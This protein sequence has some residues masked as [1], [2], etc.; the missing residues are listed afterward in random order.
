MG[1]WSGGVAPGFFQS[2]AR[3]RTATL[4]LAG[5]LS[6][7]APIT[8]QPAAASTIHPP[9]SGPAASTGT[10]V[11]PNDANRGN[12]GNPR[13]VAWDRHFD[14]NRS[15]FLADRSDARYAVYR[16]PD[17]TET[18]RMSVDDRL[19]PNGFG[20]WKPLDLALTYGPDG[21]LEP[22]SPIDRTSFAPTIQP[23]LARLATATGN[24]DLSIPGAVAGVGGT[25][26]PGPSGESVQYEGSLASHSTLEL[27]PL[28]HGFEAAIIGLAPMPD[29]ALIEQ[30]RVP[31]GDR[32]R[33]TSGAIVV[34]DARNSEVAILSG[35]RATAMVGGIPGAS[36]QLHLLAFR[37]G[38]AVVRVMVD[39][40]WLG[41]RA[42]GTE[43]RVT[44]TLVVP[45]DVRAATISEHGSAPGEDLQVGNGGSG[46]TRTLL[47][48]PVA[49]PTGSK[50]LGATLHLFE[51]G[52]ASCTPTPVQVR[53]LDGS[54][55]PTA[56]WSNAP[57]PSSSIAASA[58]AAA[59][60]TGCQSPAWL[61]LNLSSLVGAWVSGKE[62]NNGIAVQ[63]ADEQDRMAW[64]SFAG[65][66]TP[67][68]PLLDVT[69]QA[70]RGSARLPITAARVPGFTPAVNVSSEVPKTAPLS[71]AA[72]STAVDNL[73]EVVPARTANSKTF[74]KPDKTL[75][76]QIYEG[77]IHIKD[78]TG[79]WIDIDPTL[80]PNGIGRLA[81]K[82]ANPA[83]DVALDA[84][85]A[86]LARLTI[87]SQH[88]IA[89]GYSG[90]RP[91]QGQ[92]AANSIV[93]RDISAG[94]DLQVYSRPAGVDDTLVLKSA[95]ATDTYVFPLTLKGLKVAVES[96]TGDL[97]FTDAATGAEM[98]RTPSGFMEDANVNP[99]SGL[100]AR[101]SGVT[102]H[103]V[104]DGKGGQAIQVTL[105][106]AWLSDPARVYP[107]T[108][109]PPVVTT[110]NTAQDD[111]YVDSA[112]SGDFASQTEM[113]VGTWDSGH[114]LYH[115]YMHFDLSPLNG[116]HILGATFWIYNH[117]SWS[118]QA[119]GV[120]VYRVTQ[121]WGGHSM[122]SWPGASYGEEIAWAAFAHGYTPGGCGAAWQ[123]F[124]VTGAVT[125][126]TNGSWPQYGLM[127]RED[128]VSTGDNYAWKRF[129]TYD[130]GSATPHIDVS[131][132][133]RPSMATL[134]SPANG[135]SMNT[136]TPT[137]SA[138][139]SSPQGYPIN[140]HYYI[141]DSLAHAQ[142]VNAS[143][144][145]V[146]CYLVP[147]NGSSV[148]VPAPSPL[149][150]NTQY[151]WAVLVD[152][153]VDY[154]MQP[155]TIWSF[156]AG[157]PP[158]SINQQQVFT[159]P[160]PTASGTQQ[161]TVTNY[162]SSTW[163]A[164]IVA[165][166]QLF[167]AAGSKQLLA[168]GHQTVLPSS[169]AP[170]ASLSMT[171]TLDPV[172][173]GTYTVYWDLEQTPGNTWFYSPPLNIPMLWAKVPFTSVAPPTINST[174]PANNAAPPSLTPTLSVSAT[175]PQGQPLTYHF[176]LC[177]GSDAN[178]G[179]CSDSGTISPSAWTIPKNTLSWGTTYYWVVYVS[180]S[181]G[182][183]ASAIS[184][185]IP[186]LP[187]VQPAWSFGWDPFASYSAGVNTALGNYVTSNTDLKIA[188]VGPSLDV[189]RTFNSMDAHTGWFGKGWSS[190]YETWI[191][192][193][194]DSYAN[195]IIHYPDGRLEF[196]SNNQDGTFADA[197]GFP[198]HL[199]G[200]AS[201]GYTLTSPDHS[202]LT[203]AA[204]SGRLTS[205]QDSNGRLLTLSYNTSTPPQL[206]TV[207]DATSGRAVHLAWTGNQ[208]SSISSDVPSTGV[209]PLTVYYN[210]TAGQLTSV[211]DARS[212]SATD[213]TYCTTF[214][215]TGGALT[216]ISR[217]LGNVGLALTYDPSGRVA[218]LQDGMTPANVWNYAYAASTVS[219]ETKQTTVTDA[220]GNTAVSGYNSLN[221][222]M[223]H[224]DE[225]G[226]TRTYGFDSRGL[227][228]L[229]KDENGNTTTFNHDARGNISSLIDG[230]GHT[231][232]FDYYLNA[233]NPADLRNDRL[234]HQRDARSSSATDNT[235]LTQLDY[236][237]LGNLIRQT[238]PP[239]PDVAGG[240]VTTWTYSD[241]TATYPAYGGGNTPAG[242]LVQVQDP[243]GNQTKYA[244]DV[245]GDLRQMTDPV[246]LV[247]TYSYDNLG[248]RISKT[249]MATGYSSGLTTQYSYD[250]IGNV[251]SATDPGVTNSVTGVTHTRVTTTT[252]DRNGN[253][254][255]VVVSDTTGGDTSRTTSY[256]YDADD[257][258]STVT[259][260][261]N[262][263]TLTYYDQ[264]GN[265][266][267][268]VDAAGHETDSTYTARNL[269]LAITV[270]GFVDNPV[271]GTT[272]RDVVIAQYAYDA[273][274][275]RVSTT[276]AL[277]RQST[278]TWTADNRLKQATLVN[279][280][281]LDGT[282]RNI[283]LAAM[284]YD[285]VG[286]ITGATVG[287]PGT[288]TS[289]RTFTYDA[290]NHLKTTTLD[291][292]GLNRVTS[293]SYD[294]TGNVLTS[295][296]TD[297]TV[298]ESTGYIYDAAGRATQ[299]SVA[300]GSTSLV[301]TNTYD[302]R[303][304]RTATF[305]PRGNVT[306]GT[307]SAYETDFSYDAAGNL[308]T[309]TSPTV[310]V[311]SGGA[312]AVQARAATSQGYNTFG[313]LTQSKDANGYVTTTA[314]DRLSRR[315]SIAYP[316]YTTPATQSSPGGT[317]INSVESWTYDAVGD[318]LRYTDPRGQATDY[319]YDARGRLVQQSDPLLS[320]QSARGTVTNTYDDANNQLSSV[321]QVGARREATYD[322]LNRVRTAT[323]VV[324]GTAT[325]RYTTT[326][327]YNDLN[328][329]VLVTS[330][331]GENNTNIYDN[332]GEL[333]QATDGNGLVTTFTYDL[334]G[335]LR[336]TTDGLNRATENVYDLAGRLITINNYDHTG[337]L[338]TQQ[339]AGYDAAGN[340]ISLASPNG[341]VGGYATTQN[342]D[343]MSRLTSLVE[344]VSAS[345]SVTTSFG[346]DAAGHQTRATDGNGNATIK[347]YNSLGLPE[348]TIEPA[349]SAYPAAADRTYTAT[350]DAGGLPVTY[351]LPGVT[352]TRTFDQ[353]G[354]LTAE[355][356][357]G[358]G[359]T[360]ASRT[361]GW[362]MAGNLTSVNHP[363]GTI[364]F[365][366]DDRG[367][368]TAES[369]PSDTSSFTYDGD[370]RLTSRTDAAG[371][372]NF[373][374]LGD[375]LLKTASDP[376]T[377][378]TSTLGYDA[379]GQLQ[380]IST[381]T[382]AST[383]SFTYDDLG[384]V[385][386]DTLGDPANPASATHTIAYGYDANSNRTSTVVGPATLTNSA[387]YN[388]T[389][390][391][392]RANRLTSWTDNTAHTT[393]TYGWDNAGNM[394]S[395]GSATA[396][397]DQRD[398][399]ITDTSG[400]SYT[401]TARGTLSSITSPAALTTSY[402]FDALGRMTTDYAN[403]SFAYDGLDRLASKTV[404]F[405]GTCNPICAAP[406]TAPK[407]KQQPACVGCPR[408]PI[409]TTLRY[410]GADPKPVSDGKYT[411][412][413]VPSGSVL[414]MSNGTTPRLAGLDAHGDL[415][416]TY[417][418]SGAI[419]DA[420]SY[421]PFG[422]PKAA[423][424]AGGPT[425][426]YQGEWTSESNVN[427]S[428]SW[429]RPQSGTF[430]S[431]DSFSPPIQ[432]ASD[433]NRYLY[434][435]ANPISRSD[436]SGNYWK[437]DWV[438]VC[439]NWF[440]WICTQSHLQQNWTWVPDWC[441]QPDDCKYHP[442]TSDCQ[443]PQA[444]SQS[445]PPAPAPPPTSGPSGGGHSGSGGSGNHGGGGGSGGGGTQTPNPGPA[446]S[447][448]SAY[449]PNWPAHIQPYPSGH[450]PAGGG[451]PPPIAGPGPTPSASVSETVAQNQSASNGGAPQCPNCSQLHGNDGGIDWGHQATDFLK[452]VGGGLL[453]LGKG[454]LG[455]AKL[456]GQCA[457]TGVTGL[458]P[459]GCH[460]TLK[461]MGS[462]IV[463]HPTD[464]L[465]Q[466]I[467]WNDWSHGRYAVAAGHVLPS[468]VLTI[469]TLGAG[470]LLAKGSE[471]AGI[472]EEAAST[473]GDAVAAGAEQS[474]PD[475]AIIVRGGTADIPGPGKPFS[476]AFGDTE[477]AA[478]RGIPHGQYRAA[479]AGAIRAGH[480]TVDYAPEFDP[481][482]GKINYQHVNV[483]LGD[484]LCPFGDLSTNPWPRWQR[485]GGP[486]YP[487][488]N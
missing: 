420:A 396:S 195:A 329:P 312:T 359:V 423:F 352:L 481:R 333:T 346:Y 287:T 479:S 21:R 164:G 462:Y 130:Y 485:W 452:G 417:N 255:T 222:L 105:N 377:G 368:I 119:R 177:T 235:Y 272:P 28:S 134:V 418:S 29:S 192:T 233:T 1:R 334:R 320:G 404:S 305:D 367:L 483:C 115:S 273:G 263:T 296:V 253:V 121:G 26:Q 383:R 53:A 325:A 106:R 194:A 174:S 278:Y 436:P 45:S 146:P 283:I 335:R 8:S 342:F 214:T 110:A 71:A 285:A 178:S 393:T 108:V 374:Y 220:R 75:V 171:A 327:D 460:K 234:I 397:Y 91:G 247:T 336:R 257:R 401:W 400:N 11:I 394:V 243:R 264:G 20:G 443:Y 281:N 209:P 480:G 315:T 193:T 428:A 228:N 439:D 162:T 286:N 463:N 421:D 432:T 188:T 433:T 25:R 116:K 117:W 120:G 246:G 382:A 244:Y 300:N 133:D 297:G 152:D 213:A 55:V 419:I 302:S 207:T 474:I 373:T 242:L 230:A 261:E 390:G 424:T 453:D 15:V 77:P 73:A 298:T 199:T 94:V 459:F 294:A 66:M 93:Y 437:M 316:T 405:P 128:T 212:V 240:A 31:A 311:E 189:T 223:R 274:G 132:K 232:Y 326:Y 104:P 422:T 169:V 403:T 338:L 407:G 370:G 408:P 488:V 19:V 412:S 14:P 16:N 70:P 211:C 52:A 60:A 3:R 293:L 85:D 467:D 112:A 238:D 310:S 41:Q 145:S 270:K 46:S 147:G 482:V 355:S 149:S 64:K 284:A 200:S 456:G 86:A 314:Y 245:K 262:G 250:G 254:A 203:F 398:R 109:D 351:N 292:G 131:W 434:A 50:F 76:T 277:G 289:T 369:G 384:R 12:G 6:V 478:A 375:G 347:T 30:V 450:A 330:P 406:A 215:Y 442:W 161:M 365:T 129:R 151:W 58:R 381:G 259:N 225:E 360:S 127:I 415:T 186:T 402:D 337:A 448:R 10:P 399:L 477:A 137:L 196:H 126:W 461:A 180:N 111:T 7:I 74:V 303:G 416:Y 457:F 226:N 190:T 163:G 101:S 391:Y 309:T 451:L 276:D 414:G 113:F 13:A 83:L 42:R 18:A 410:S 98:A 291:P 387:S 371:T 308:V 435:D 114:S 319:V 170:G 295:S 202:Q 80:L 103:L 237:P 185:I 72:V 39:P 35:G 354:R 191:E 59:G 57:Q 248:R 154:N 413:R 201:A 102:Y 484:G 63:V 173:P 81:T 251:I 159:P 135:A 204:S 23:G 90:A 156:T 79:A 429:Y 155:P 395:V 265:V 122:T 49:L 88:S 260:P 256:T 210:Y 321:N 340:A 4:L 476:G 332:A 27:T 239:T 269:P 318:V 54:F 323:Q 349:T 307:P 290:A 217:P 454:A 92:A 266:T 139:A 411:Y 271:T 97:V 444:P 51:T 306:G 65:P 339:Q 160:T 166:Y 61:S 466:M 343:A 197:L 446:D 345:S 176:R 389:Y 184:T 219:G 472:T 464:V 486:G 469:G 144:S 69:Y 87:D 324:R 299:Q 56:D 341:V 5:A 9:G 473:A 48:W 455:A 313:D 183:A 236:D 227:V 362:D 385:T 275:R 357:S 468:L 267:R 358:T 449:D 175:D 96:S 172:S 282:V 440:L 143:V 40:A 372:A 241:G 392:D 363:K 348:S 138:S 331:L 17:G 22:R 95:S 409:V 379:A 38:F 36:V 231:T 364:T 33:E 380:S 288:G 206:I 487:Y 249:V 447:N 279:Y 124:D 34:F 68:G 123:P 165:S 182:T 150:P 441:G 107:V 148:T 181:N 252:Y 179:A 229:V 317:V 78:P 458:D 218:T 301:T 268:L 221:Q 67:T 168:Q 322:D 350:Y 153:T 280:H 427:M 47:S 216:K 141:C 388:Y 378:S 208:P 470:G 140:Y 44:T 438:S 205:S 62:P 366:N 356:G 32:V 100:G 376:L 89:F 167:D 2:G 430:L 465:G 386:S 445:Q 24:I 157:I 431:R 84:T 125:N 426:G 99:H 475:S 425:I 353:L 258:V 142:Q 471:L 136:L 43:V 304:L 82:A 198:G 187:V 361:L 224:V 328:N 118:C 37:A 158:V 344:P